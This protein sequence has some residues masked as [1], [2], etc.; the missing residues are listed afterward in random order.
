MTHIPA[1]A[2]YFWSSAF[3]ATFPTFWNIKQFS[4]DSAKLRIFFLKKI[5]NSQIIVQ[6]YEL[7]HAV[8]LRNGTFIQNIEMKIFK[9][10]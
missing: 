6:F 4:N 2:N 3:S 7:L 8:H 5:S 1:R 9:I 10:I